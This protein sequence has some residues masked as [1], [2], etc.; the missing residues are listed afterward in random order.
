M[1]RLKLFAAFA[2][3]SSLIFISTPQLFADETSELI[4]K[5]LVKKGIIS[6]K[7]VE[8]LRAEIKKEKVPE[9]IEE[10]IA[11]LEEKAE[12]SFVAIGQGDLKIGGYVQTRYTHNQLDSASDSFTIS[13]AKISLKGHLVPEVFYKFEIGPHKSSSILYDAYTKLSYIP[14]MDITVGQFKIPFAKEFLTSSS[15]IDTISRSNFMTSSKLANEYG[16]GAMISSK[17]LF[18][19][20]LE[21]YAA[22]ESGRDRNGTEDTDQESVTGRLVLNPFKNTESTRKVNLKGL[23]LGFSTQVGQQDS[24]ATYEGLR[25][26][27]LGYVKYDL[28][29]IFTD[30]DYLKI[31]SEYI[32]QE[33]DRT[34]A[35]SDLES[36]GWYILANYKFPV[37][38][39][40]QNMFLEP[41]LKFER[42]EP[43]KDTGGDQEEWYTAGVNLHVNKYVKWMT[44]YIWKEEESGSEVGDNQFVTQLQYKF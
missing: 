20:V 17:D 41:V 42:Y 6:N 36:D 19:G 24:T 4:L 14:N 44:N 39:F 22:I 25:E 26:R 32:F 9:S 28:K 11:T 23:Q 5:I 34:G 30:K 2:L 1:K 13:N 8:Q 18:D 43:D 29:D 15:A 3:C 27:Y 21:Y 33:R 10:R 35:T 12:K 31:Q 7:E 40:N 16:I 38:L 37:T